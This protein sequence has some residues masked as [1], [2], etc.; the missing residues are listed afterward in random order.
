VTHRA[1]SRAI[2]YQLDAWAKIPPEKCDAMQE[3]TFRDPITVLSDRSRLFLIEQSPHDGIMNEFQ[4]MPTP[5][6]RERGADLNTMEDETF[7]SIN[8]GEQP[9]SAIDTYV[10][11]WKRLTGDEITEEVNEWYSRR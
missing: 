9:L 10:T 2:R 8:V 5:T 3:A 7:I 11:N 6:Q 1:D 4:G